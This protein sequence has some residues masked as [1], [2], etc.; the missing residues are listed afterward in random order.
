[1]HALLL[2]ALFIATPTAEAT[3]VTDDAR[4]TV[5]DSEHG[6]LTVNMVQFRNSNGQVLISLYNTSDGFPTKP[7][8]AYKGVKTKITGRVAQY[9]FEGLPAGEYAVSIAHDENNNGQLD[10]SW[11]GIP[12][13]GV[14]ASNNPRPRMGPPRYRDAKF[15]VGAGEEVTKSVKLVYVYNNEG[16]I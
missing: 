5:D 3:S 15:N 11:I 8:R 10:T 9:V 1:M 13:E 4:V 6:T 14:G 2:S 7:A 12:R 16:N